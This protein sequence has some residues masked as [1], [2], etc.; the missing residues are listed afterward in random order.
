MHRRERAYGTF[1]RTVQL[2]F[3]VDPDKVRARFDNGILESSWNGGKRI[4]R[5]RSRSALRDLSGGGAIIAQELSPVDQRTPRTP[6]SGERTVTR[7]VFVP[8]TD[9]YET[10]DKISCSPRYLV[11]LPMRWTSPSSGGC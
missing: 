8:P 5:K 6:D 7:P 1:S 11:S 2:P 3:R 9:I 10:S 4:G